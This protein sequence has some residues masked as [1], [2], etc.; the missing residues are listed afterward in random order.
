MKVALTELVRSSQQL[1]NRV[2]TQTGAI[3]DS[4][5]DPAEWKQRVSSMY[6]RL[7]ETVVP[8][9][10]RCFE[11]EVDLDPA[12]LTLPDDHYMSIGVDLIRGS[13]CRIELPEIMIEERNQLV[14]PGATE[15]EGWALI[16]NAL[17]LYPATTRGTYK[18]IYIPQP[19][20]LSSAADET[21][22]DVLTQA[23]RDLIEWGVAAIALHRDDSNQTRAISERD[24][25]AT[26]LLS[27]AVQRS[28][29]QPKRQ[30]VHDFGS[31]R[32]LRRLRH[33]WWP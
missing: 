2:A 26:R 4:Q 18:H 20:D 27:W 3:A 10:A 29:T 1:A 12:V 14:R 9:G 5:V 8:T 19:V 33:R 24:G 7:H 32:D 30:R 13:T 23:G 21:I 11:V 16:G 28:L 25:A 22:V 31:F 15:A 6:G 17:R